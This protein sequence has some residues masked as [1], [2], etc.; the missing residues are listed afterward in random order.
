MASQSNAARDRSHHD[1]HETQQATPSHE[2]LVT[3]QNHQTKSS[4]QF[5]E[6][7]PETVPPCQILV[8]GENPADVVDAPL[9]KFGCFITLSS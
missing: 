9:S 5:G 3:D 1:F 7:V 6:S 8:L 2:P 4:Q